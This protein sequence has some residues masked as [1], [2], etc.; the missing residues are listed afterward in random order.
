MC[1]A[2]KTQHNADNGRIGAKM[3]QMEAKRTDE[4]RWRKKKKT[5]RNR[6]G[7]GSLMYIGV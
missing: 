2:D 3:A 4:L 5:P 1:N 6:G 7:P